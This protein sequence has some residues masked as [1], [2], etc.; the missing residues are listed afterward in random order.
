MNSDF[1]SYLLNNSEVVNV[2]ESSYAIKSIISNLNISQ[3][4]VYEQDQ[5]IDSYLS[6][7]VMNNV[8]FTNITFTQSVIKTILSTLIG[9]DIIIANISNP[10]NSTNSFISCSTDSSIFIDGLDY[11]QSQASLMLLNNVTGIVD[12][13]SIVSS[14]SISSMIEIDD[15]Y[16]LEL[17][18]LLANNT[19]SQTKSIIRIKDS[20]SRNMENLTFSHI[21][22]L[23][24]EVSNSV[25]SK[26]SNTSIKS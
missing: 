5:F 17:I 16:G 19:S 23:A 15:S 18:S 1:K 13:L 8:N 21:P 25:I 4:N 7:M 22:H 6:T 10:N 20:I 3:V 24:I 9:S 26:M 2:I 12:K 14:D 11:L